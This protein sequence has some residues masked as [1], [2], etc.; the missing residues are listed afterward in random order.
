[1]EEETYFLDCDDEGHWYVIPTSKEAD[2]S[3][4]VNRPDLDSGDFPH[5]VYLNGPPSLVRFRSFVVS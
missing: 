1:M 4:W 3:E 5:A 2:W